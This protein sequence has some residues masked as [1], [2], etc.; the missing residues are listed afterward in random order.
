MCTRETWLGTIAVILFCALA[1]GGPRTAYAQGD[2]YRA[3]TITLLATTAPGGTGDLRVKAMAQFVK[4]CA[5]KSHGGD[6]VHGW[7]RGRK[8]ANHL[9]NSVRPDGLT[10]GAA[11]G[12][13][14]GLAV[15]G[16]KGVPYDP[17]KFL[18]LGTP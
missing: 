4:T 3:K 11:S 8:G 10:I 12:G 7:R 18:Y 6:R 15:M 14:V 13:I 1:A 16:E 2:F 17:D 5:G 9:Y